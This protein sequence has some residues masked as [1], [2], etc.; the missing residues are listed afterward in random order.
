[1]TSDGHEM[2]AYLQTLG[3][4]AL[5]ASCSVMFSPMG[6]MF[7]I[8]R[9][10]ASGK[11]IIGLLVPYFLLFTQCFLWSFYGIFTD[12]PEIT[13]VNV[14]GTVMCCMYLWI[15]T[16]HAKEKDRRVLQPVVALAAVMLV[17][18][19]FGFIASFDP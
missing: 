16:S 12:H 14:L 3:S 7:T 17:V 13:R 6:S 9:Y 8:M 11:E 4:M 10:G 18:V 5:V 15:M 1:M 2:D 19:S